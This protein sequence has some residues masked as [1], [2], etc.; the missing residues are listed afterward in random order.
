[1]LAEFKL[2]DGGRFVL[3]LGGTCATDSEDC[4]VADEEV[5][6]MSSAATALDVFCNNSDNQIIR[7]Y[8]PT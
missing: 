4:G 5:T 6:A 7:S 2:G 8:A 1:M 3:K